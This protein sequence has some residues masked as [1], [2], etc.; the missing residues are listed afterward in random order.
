MFESDKEEEALRLVKAF[1]RIEE[2]QIRQRLISLVEAA[3]L[4]QIPPPRISRGHVT[5]KVEETAGFD[6]ELSSTLEHTLI[7]VSHSNGSLHDG[8]ANE[9]VRGILDQSRS[10]NARLGVTGALLFTGS[11]FC[12]VLEGSRD[13][14]DEI[15]DSIQR[16]QRHRNVSLLSFRPTSSRLFP[17]WSMAYAG[18]TADPAWTFGSDDLFASPSQINGDHIGQVLLSLMTEFVRQEETNLH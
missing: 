9:A 3:A 6:E 8:P 4:S 17:Q 13:A 16:D 12:Q 10:R 18:L 11:C 5:R 15:F 1:F 2:R 7:Y 14:V